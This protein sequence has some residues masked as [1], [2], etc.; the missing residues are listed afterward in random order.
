DLSWTARTGAL[1]EDHTEMT[2]GPTVI[3]DMARFLQF[4]TW[5]GWV[6]AGGVTTD[7]DDDRVLGVRDRSWGVRPVGERPGGR[8]AEHGSA[9]WFWMPIHFDDECRTT[10]WF[11]RPGGEFWRADGHRLPVLDPVPLSIDNDHPDVFRLD[12]VAQDVVFEPDTR[13]ISEARFTMRTPSGE[14]V[15]DLES[16]HHFHMRGLG[17]TNL[18]WGHGMW[19]G[20]LAVGSEHWRFA[21]IDAKDPFHQHLHHVVK[22]NVDG[23]EGV[24]LLE[25]IIF[26]PHTQFGFTEWL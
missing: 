13:R 6:T 10:G 26:G 20:E 25:Q 18:D 8:P 19:K 17:Y 21:D 11:Q 5:S 15:L 4:G 9:C 23:R 1:L 3:I 24:G 12:P 14:Q 16:L 2:S 7:L 22:A